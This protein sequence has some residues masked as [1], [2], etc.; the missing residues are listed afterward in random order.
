MGASMVYLEKPNTEVE[1]QF[2]ESKAYGVKYSAAE[3]Q[4]WRLNMVSG[5]KSRNFTRKGRR[6]HFKS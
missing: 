5:H 3:M 1:H 4:G 2:G 6:T